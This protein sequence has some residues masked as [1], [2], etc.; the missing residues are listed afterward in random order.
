MHEA[1]HIEL[2]D[3]GAGSSVVL[4]RSRPIRQDTASSN[5]EGAA[6]AAAL[7]GWDNSTTSMPRSCDRSWRT[8][9]NGATIR[10]EERARRSSRK[11]WQLIWIPTLKE[12]PHRL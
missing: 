1:R 6:E 8:L 4:I 5:G 2:N 11:P 9:L 7:I 10:S 3:F 12:T